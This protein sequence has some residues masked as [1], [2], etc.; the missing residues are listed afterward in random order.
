MAR[1]QHLLLLDV[2]L[3]DG[4]EI[5]T[6]VHGAFVLGAQKGTHHLVGRYT[7][8]AE[9][10]LLELPTQVLDLKLQLVDLSQVLVRR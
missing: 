3:L 8:F 9:R 2:L 7:H 10:R 6:Q 1:E 5:G 4:L